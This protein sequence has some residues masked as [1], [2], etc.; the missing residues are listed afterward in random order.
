MP[1]VASADALNARL[2]KVPLDEPLVRGAV[3]RVPLIASP[4]MRV[5]LLEYP[6]RFR[7]IRHR[8][9]G[10]GEF[11]LIVGGSGTFRIGDSGPLAVASG[12]LLYA[13]MDESHFI[14]AGQQGLR[15]LA[16]VSPNEDRSDEAVETQGDLTEP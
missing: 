7:T 3:H 16:G 2:T 13:R 15:F 14:E 8:H 9:P 10:A 1:F 4:S 12:D 5:V 6:P 11:F